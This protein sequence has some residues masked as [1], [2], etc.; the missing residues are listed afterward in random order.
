MISSGMEGAWIY[1]KIL[2]IDSCRFDPDTNS[3]L[4]RHHK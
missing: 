4:F 1:E 3:F 2:F